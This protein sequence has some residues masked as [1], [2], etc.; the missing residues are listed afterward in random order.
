M[1]ETCVR[2]CST[3]PDHSEKFEA[4][5]ASMF[6]VPCG[7][8]IYWMS[9]LG[10]SI[11]YGVP[12]NSKYQY[13][14]PCSTCDPAT[15]VERQKGDTVWPCSLPLELLLSMFLSDGEDDIIPE[16]VAN[17]Y[18]VDE[19]DEP[20]SFA[21]LPFR[22]ST[23]DF[24]GQLDNRIFMCGD[25]VSTHAKMHEPVVAWTLELSDLKPTIYALTSKRIW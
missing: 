19:T 25:V 7:Q 21:V 11:S 17:Y 8:L 24:R 20:T 6:L 9:E 22:K 13:F 23:G 5:A 4:L 1:N 14:E 18:F 15:E 10:D 2:F 3:G 12:R 16:K